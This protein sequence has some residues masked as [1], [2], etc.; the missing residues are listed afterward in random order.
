LA[1]PVNNKKKLGC[2]G[3]E[4]EGLLD[5]VAGAFYGLP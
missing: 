1:Q 2:K 4:K 5:L 3:G